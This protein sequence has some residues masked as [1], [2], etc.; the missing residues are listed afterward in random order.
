MTGIQELLWLTEGACR[1]Q[2]E[3]FYFISFY[4]LS[5]CDRSKKDHQVEQE[6]Q[7]EKNQSTAHLGSWN[8]R[9]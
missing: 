5:P 7:L 1:G 3:F 2:L 9:Q 4:E 8:L 6:Q